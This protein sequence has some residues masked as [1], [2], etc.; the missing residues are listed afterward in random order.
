MCVAVLHSVDR[1]TSYLVVW[2]LPWLLL[3]SLSM[4]VHSATRPVFAAWAGKSRGVTRSM[5]GKE[6]AGHLGVTYTSW[7]VVA[8]PRVRFGNMALS[9]F[10]LSAVVFYQLLVCPR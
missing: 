5:L 9:S 2:S 7:L 6:Q 4:A 1:S 3:V 10:D 8:A